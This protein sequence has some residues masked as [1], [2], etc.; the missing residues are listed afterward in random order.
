MD[1]LIGGRLASGDDSGGE[2]LAGRLLALNPNDNHGARALIVCADLQHG[3]DAA[4][5]ALCDRFAGDMLAEIAFGRVLALY[6]LGREEEATDSL[7]GAV[8]RHPPLARILTTK[9]APRINL[10][11]SGYIL[12]S[13]EEAAG[14]RKTMRDTWAETPGALEWLRRSAR[15]LSK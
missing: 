13:D 7:R 1:R 14:Y 2:W 5:L 10:D 3:R 9:R 4:A 15:K 12:G 6:R 11:P 8:E